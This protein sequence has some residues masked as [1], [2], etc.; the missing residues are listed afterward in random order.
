MRET[1]TH[2]CCA[3]DHDR[4]RRSDSGGSQ[5][6]SS[7]KAEDGQ[8]QCRAVASDRRHTNYPSGSTRRTCAATQ[9]LNELPSTVRV[10]GD[11]AVPAATAPP[12]PPSAEHRWNAD[13]LTVTSTPPATPPPLVALLQPISLL[14]VITI[15]PDAYTH[16]PPSCTVTRARIAQGQETCLREE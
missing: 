1:N 3:I 16:P 12:T 15:D 6:S 8:N 11:P 13:D 2:F 10:D 14:F 9:L 5:R 7:L 4:L